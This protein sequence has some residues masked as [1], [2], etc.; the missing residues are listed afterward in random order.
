MKQKIFVYF[1][2]A[3]L[4]VSLLGAGVASAH[5]LG[6]GLGMM[7]NLS[8]D[9]VATR[10]TAM[11]Q[12]QAQ[13]LGITVDEVKKGWAEGKTL[14][15]IAADKNITPEQLKVKMKEAHLAMMKTHLQALVTKG[16]ITQAQADQRFS[17]MQKMMENGKARLG[18]GMSRGMHF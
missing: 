7:S 13:L 18:K 9:E 12:N 17:V 2:P 16:V 5:G 1:V 4:G 3:V 15:Q 8:A 6:G 11:F 10:Q 14:Q